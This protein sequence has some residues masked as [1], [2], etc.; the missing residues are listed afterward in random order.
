MSTPTFRCFRCGIDVSRPNAACMDCRA[1]DPH[2]TGAKPRPKQKPRTR[3]QR[4]L[5]PLKQPQLTPVVVAEVKAAL[6]AGASQA[7]TARRLGVPLSTVH[8]I[9][10]GKTWTHIKATT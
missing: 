8:N 10:T 4:N 3:E 7:G 6:N 5:P 2:Y 9:A 1:T